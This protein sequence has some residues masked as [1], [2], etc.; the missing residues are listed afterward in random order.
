MVADSGSETASTSSDRPNAVK[1]HDLRKDYMVGGEPLHVLKGIDLIVPEGDYVAIMG[2]SGSGKSTLLNVLGCLDQA[3]SGE[4]LLGGEEVSTL[5]DDRL[6]EI[7]A[8]NIGF[9]FQSY[10]LITTLTVEENIQAPLFYAGHITEEDRR[11][12]VE[13]A[14]KVGLSER[15][16]HRP[17]QLSGGQQQR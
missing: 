14:A 17:A 3:T 11:R 15:L 7:R 16:D 2:P 13:L 9:V 4:F 8:Q 10:N 12:S 5:D 1:I 6:A